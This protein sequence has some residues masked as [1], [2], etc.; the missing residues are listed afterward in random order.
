MRIFNHSS[1][2][3]DKYRNFYFEPAITMKVG[4]DKL[5][6]IIQAGA[7]GRLEDRNSYPYDYRYI[8]ISI[9]LQLNLG[10]SYPTKSTLF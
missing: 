5:K 8:I 4:Y 7:S 1:F 6:F 9:G 10:R 3:T 2:I